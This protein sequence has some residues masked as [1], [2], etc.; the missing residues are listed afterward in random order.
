MKAQAL[1]NIVSPLLLDRIENHIGLN[2]CV[3]ERSKF[4]GWL[5]V[6]IIDVLQRHNYNAKPEIDRIDISFD[7]TA[8]E[9]KTINT[10]YRFDNVVN[11]TRPITKNIQGII[12]DIDELKKKEIENRFILFVVFPIKMEQKEWGFHI[13]KIKNELC[14]LTLTEF[15]F[16]NGIPGALYCG[17][18]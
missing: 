18:I 11:K 10:N 2:Q 13:E 5:K 9:L 17:K 8:I 4:E 7:D 12:H 3:V 15:K 14:E 16:N 6:E 1:L